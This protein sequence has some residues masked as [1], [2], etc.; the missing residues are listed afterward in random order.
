MHQLT[1]LRSIS[2]TTQQVLRA[3]GL[4]L[5]FILVSTAQETSD[6]PTK[7]WVD[8]ALQFPAAPITENLLR[9]YSN[10]NQSFFIDSKS[11]SIVAD[12]SLRYTIVSTSQSGAKNVSYEGIRCDSYEK[13]LFA[14]GRADGSWSPSRRNEWDEISNK[15]VNKQHSSLAWDFVCEAGS[16]AG[17]VEKIIQRLKTNQSLKQYH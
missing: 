10:E 2:C 9:F 13:R 17:N 5:C 7:T 1:P 8:S 4:S 12:G 14:F 3:C 11:L 16:I 15:G 6:K